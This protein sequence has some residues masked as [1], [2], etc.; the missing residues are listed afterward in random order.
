[1]RRQMELMQRELANLRALQGGHGGGGASAFPPAHGNAPMPVVVSCT[2][3]A[4]LRRDMDETKKE[5]ER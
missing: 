4:A 1:M 2:D 3:A 5:L